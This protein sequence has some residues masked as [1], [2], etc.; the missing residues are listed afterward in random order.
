MNG[1]QGALDVAEAHPLDGLEV[2]PRHPLPR[3]WARRRRHVASEEAI[4]GHERRPG[5]AARLDAVEHVLAEG[6]DHRVGAASEEGDQSLGVRGVRGRVRMERGHHEARASLVADRSHQGIEVRASQTEARIDEEHE[7]E[8]G[9]LPASVQGPSTLARCL[10][11]GGAQRRDG[12][13]K[14]NYLHPLLSERRSGPG[15]EIEGQDHLVD[16]APAEPDR[17]ALQGG[18]VRG[19]EAPQRRPRTEARRDGAR[20]G[21][22]DGAPGGSAPEGSAPEETARREGAR[23]RVH[24]ERVDHLDSN[25]PAQLN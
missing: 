4:Q 19:T 23:H 1:E 3:R 24:D 9:A 15:T 7:L 6:L 10:H 5:A 2:R 20:A 21:G 13:G 22:E 8:L 25:G 11:Q 16:V 17:F 18:V 14:G 12:L